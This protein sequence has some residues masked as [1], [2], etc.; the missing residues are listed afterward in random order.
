V[1]LLEDPGKAGGGRVVSRPGRSL[2]Y[3]RVRGTEDPE[4]PEGLPP[5]PFNREESSLLNE[6]RLDGSRRAEEMA[7]LLR[8]G[9]IPFLLYTGSLI[10]LLVSLRF[11][12][13]LSNWPLAN[14]LIGALIFR[15]VLIFEGFIA[16]QDVRDLVLSF[17]GNRL[18]E[19]LLSPLIFCALG[20]LFSLYT[21]LVFLAR[22]RKAGAS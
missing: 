13:D 20:L 5:A 3:Q 9:R 12:L 22:D 7:L 10:F 18:P 8:Q 19:S 4:G 17:I 2:I 1:I 14:L 15:G 11:V 21:L 6:L 16:L